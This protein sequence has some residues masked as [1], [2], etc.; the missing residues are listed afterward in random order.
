MS[1]HPDQYPSRIEGLGQVR[2]AAG[3]GLPM[4]LWAVPGESG[5]LLLLRDV[6]LL[7]G[8]CSCRVGSGVAA[9]AIQEASK[10]PLIWL[11]FS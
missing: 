9:A 10:V 3:S 6:Y 5:F 7:G 4:L 1:F 11:L 2:E 8:G